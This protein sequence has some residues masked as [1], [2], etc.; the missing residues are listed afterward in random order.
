MSQVL[1]RSQNVAWIWWVA[2][3]GAAIDPGGVLAE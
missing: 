1:R 2:A 3:A